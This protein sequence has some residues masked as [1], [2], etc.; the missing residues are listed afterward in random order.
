MSAPC[1]ARIMSH[2]AL[3]P[4]FESVAR[5][6]DVKE[7]DILRVSHPERTGGRIVEAPVERYVDPDYADDPG[8]LRIK[9]Y[10]ESP[11]GDWDYADYSMPP[12]YDTG[13]TVHS[14]KRPK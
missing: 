14:I 11:E 10:P 5:L 2:R 7:G 3:G 1:Y 4:Q 12:T 8:H 6:D 13:L 9:V